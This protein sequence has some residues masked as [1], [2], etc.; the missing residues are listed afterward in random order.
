M[1]YYAI[2]IRSQTEARY[3]SMARR[4][5]AEIGENLF[6]LRRSLRV[7]KGGR[8]HEQTAPIFSGYVFLRIDS[9]DPD[10]SGTLRS[11]P[12]FIRFLPANDRIQPLDD[13][14]EAMLRH[15]LSFGEVVS[16]SVVQFDENHRITVVSGPLKGLDGRIVKVDRR[17][18]RARV[19]L[20]LYQETFEIDFGFQALEP[21]AAKAGPDTEAGPEW[22]SS[23]S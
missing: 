6:F 21:S 17:K 23:S 14:D 15:F 2:Q 19:R 3:V 5:S 9:L 22:E 7:K 16:K 18:Q 11:L 10:T 13:R 20:E 4:L 1:S 8:W 12:G